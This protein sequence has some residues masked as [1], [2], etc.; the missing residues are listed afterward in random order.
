MEETALEET[1]KGSRT[2]ADTNAKA[3]NGQGLSRREAIQGIRGRTKAKTKA[4]NGQ[5]LGSAMCS[6]AKARTRAESGHVAR[7]W[8]VGGGGGGV[9]GGV[10]AGAVAGL[11][12]LMMSCKAAVSCSARAVQGSTALKD[13]RGLD[14]PPGAGL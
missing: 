11:Q 2:K 8:Q 1:A 4:R 10:M 12:G 9:G 6:A 7:W 5:S 3:R 13:P 14:H